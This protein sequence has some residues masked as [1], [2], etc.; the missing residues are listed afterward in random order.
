MKTIDVTTM[1]KLNRIGVFALAALLA[2]CSGTPDNSAEAKR[3]ELN[4]YKQELHQLEQKIALLE[5]E[6]KEAADIEYVE[7]VLNR[8]EPRFFEH[9]FEVTG[10]VEADQEVNVSP[11]GSG[12]I[13]EIKVKE[14]QRVAKGAVLAVLNSEPINRTIEEVKINLEL[15]KTTFDRQQKLWDQNI[16]SELQYLQAKSAKESLERQLEGL[17]A[18]QDMSIIKAPVDG[19]IDVIYQKQGQIASPQIPFGKLVNIERIKIYADVT[20]AYLTKIKEGDDVLVNFPSIG[21]SVSTKI[22]QIGNYIDPGNRTFRIRLD[23]QNSD[24]LIKPNM[25]AVVKIRDYVADQAIVIPSLLI[26]EDFKGKYT[27]IAE[28]NGKYLAAKKIYVNPGV[29]DNNVTEV[30]EGL[31]AGMEVISEGFSQVFDGSAVRAN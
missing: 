23:L 6:L 20:E 27:F 16:G 13:L 28:N 14:G 15:A 1:K 8:V 9:F 5:R 3:K 31:T 22:R 21:R 12:Q 19:I 29:S 11:E 7:V 2:A 26:K 25:D 30:R 4:G 18:Q 24:K 17:M 10:S